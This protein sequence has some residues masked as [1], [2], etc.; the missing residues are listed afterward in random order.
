MSF[1]PI[2]S[3]DRSAIPSKSTS[4]PARAGVFPLVVCQLLYLR[5]VVPHHEQVAIWL[6]RE[7]V[8]RFVLE[9]HPRAGEHNLLSIWRPRQMCIV[10]LGVRQSAQV[11]PVRPDGEYF[12]IIAIQPANECDQVSPR[13]PNRKIVILCR[14]R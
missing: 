3:S 12:E 13:R 4:P 8:W 2:L 7:R 1:W 10:A 11:R 14:E 9:A 5:S 6:R